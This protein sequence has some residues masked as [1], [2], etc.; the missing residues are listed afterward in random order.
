MVVNLYAYQWCKKLVI[1]QKILKSENLY[2]SE[3]GY[4]YHIKIIHSLLKN[5]TEVVYHRIFIKGGGGLKYFF[6]SLR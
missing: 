6:R 5:W 4:M 3:H 2:N 1:I